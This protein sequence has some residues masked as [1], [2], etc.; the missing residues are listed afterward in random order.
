MIL[1]TPDRGCGVVLPFRLT[2]R[3]TSV[4]LSLGVS[5][6]VVDAP[7]PNMTFNKHDPGILCLEFLRRE[8]VCR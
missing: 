5:A 6:S 8:A 1:L 3:D 7:Q 2:P 4:L